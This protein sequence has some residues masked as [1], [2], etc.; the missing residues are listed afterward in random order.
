MWKE[1]YLRSPSAWWIIYDMSVWILIEG[2]KEFHVII[3]RA[4]FNGLLM[5]DSTD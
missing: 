3:D 2:G 5:M 4:R 1:W